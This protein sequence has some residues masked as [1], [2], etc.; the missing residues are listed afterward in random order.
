MICLITIMFYH[1]D[2]LNH[3]KVTFLLI[4]VLVSLVFDLFWLITFSSGWWEGS[5][6]KFTDF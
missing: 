5:T 2:E 4:L 3:Q 6:N 1:K